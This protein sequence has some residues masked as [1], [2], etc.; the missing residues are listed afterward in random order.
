[1]S[2]APDTKGLKITICI[3][4]D[5][6][7]RMLIAGISNTLVAVSEKQW[8]RL[9]RLLWKVYREEKAAML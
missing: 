7:D 9:H 5:A 3:Q 1:V 4:P 8:P 2:E 6:K